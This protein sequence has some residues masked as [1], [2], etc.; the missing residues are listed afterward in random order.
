[1]ILVLAT[2]SY[3][4]K[5]CF[6]KMLSIL[7]SFSLEVSL[8]SGFRLENNLAM[9]LADYVK[10]CLENEC[11]IFNIDVEIIVLG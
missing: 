10:H 6:V 2:R 5:K 7:A 1:M 11:D 3:D 9:T 4:R 8:S